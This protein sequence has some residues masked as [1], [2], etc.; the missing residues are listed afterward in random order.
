[1]S[2]RALD[3]WKWACN[4]A[5]GRLTG[6]Q[7]SVLQVIA[8]HADADGG[9]AFVAQ[10]AMALSAGIGGEGEHPD[11]SPV[12]K[13]LKRLEALSLIE[14]ERRAG[15][16]TVWT[17]RLAWTPVL[18]DR[19]DA[20]DPRSN[21]TGVAHR[22][23]GPTPVQPRSSGTYEG[24]GEGT[25]TPSLSF[26]VVALRREREREEAVNDLTAHLAANLKM[27]RAD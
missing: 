25:S 20:P 4:V 10:E 15:K 26:N 21:G 8:A 27:G 19:A 16:T 11:T 6:A 14:G 1:M 3:R 17:V 23:P 9:N 5:P 12:R 24:E 2:R 22:D 7:R 13:V 18:A